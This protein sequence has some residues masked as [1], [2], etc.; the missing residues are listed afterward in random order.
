ME[1]GEKGTYQRLS[2]LLQLMRS[3]MIGMD[4]SQHSQTALKSDP[5]PTGPVS[6][7]FLLMTQPSFRPDE[8]GS[9]GRQQGTNS[10]DNPHSLTSFPLFTPLMAS[11]SHLESP[12]T[13]PLNAFHCVLMSHLSA[14]R[15]SSSSVLWLLRMAGFPPTQ[16]R[17]SQ[18]GEKWGSQ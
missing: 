4:T 9:A 16:Y 17:R 7:R 18:C 3:P 6:T 5:D 1:S 15:P 8:F 11:P 2:K 13:H 12:L 10:R 14:V